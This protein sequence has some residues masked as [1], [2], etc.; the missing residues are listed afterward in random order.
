MAMLTAIKQ[1]TVDLG[2]SS[3]PQRVE[4][5]SPGSN[6]ARGSQRDKHSKRNRKSGDHKGSKQELELLPR[7]EL[8]YSFDKRDE[9][10]QAKD[11]CKRDRRSSQQNN[12]NWDE[13]QCLPRAA[14]CSLVRTGKNPTNGTCI[15]ARVPI[16][17]QEEYE[18]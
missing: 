6:E 12:V 3:I 2:V 15:D 14:M 10:Q 8:S 11:T 17:Y 9:L 7:D 16:T 5:T 18:M 4:P 1:L 13:G